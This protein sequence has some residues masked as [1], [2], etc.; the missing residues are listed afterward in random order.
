MPIEM[1]RYS[2]S[3][4][5][6]QASFGFGDRLGCATEGHAMALL[7]AGGQIR[8]IFAQQSIREMTRTR[9]TP[10]EVMH[11]AQRGLAKV[12][13]RGVWSADAD[14]LKTADDIRATM[15]AGFVFF[16]LDPSEFVNRSA[17]HVPLD[18]LAAMFRP[19]S[20]QYSWWREYLGKEISL[21]RGRLHF[22]EE[23]VR[24]GIVKYARAIEKAIELARTV[25]HEASLRGSSWELELSVDETEE[26]TT[27][28]EH[29]MIAE[30][31]ANQ[32]V[33]LASLAPRFVGH[34]EKGVDFQG[35]IAEL[36]RTMDLHAEIA[37]RLGP[38]KLSLHSGSDKLSMYPVLQATTQGMFHVKTAGTSY[39]EGLRVVCQRDSKLFRQIVEFCRSRYDTDRASYHVSAEL[40]S[41][42]SPEVLNGEELEQVYLDRWQD[43]PP[44]QGFRALGRQ[45]LHCTFGSVLT[46]PQLGPAVLDCVRR[47]VEEYHELL[48]VHFGKHLQALRSEPLT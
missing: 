44:G 39:L 22:T 13:F 35:D 45:I 3:L 26:P 20:E 48:R 16:T 31:L 36:S 24:R 32:G 6:T 14:H 2:P 8:G 30:Q 43:V 27:P 42:P 37:R 28:E 29:Y 25:A 4:L 7:E 34:F 5:G 19:L 38:Y 41:T 46:H 17:D 1:M 18:Q 9:R 33:R 11:A 15:E 23:R 12:D 21:D 10:H 40:N 47:H